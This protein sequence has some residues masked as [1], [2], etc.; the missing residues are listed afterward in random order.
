MGRSGRGNN[1]RLHAFML[2]SCLPSAGSP[3]AIR[4]DNEVPTGQLETGRPNGWHAS[5]PSPADSTAALP[6]GSTV[7]SPSIGVQGTDGA[8][9]SVRVVTICSGLHLCGAP[10][11]TRSCSTLSQA[12]EGVTQ[13]GPCADYRGP[14]TIEHNSGLSRDLVANCPP[15][16]MNSSG[17]KPFFKILKRAMGIEPTTYSLGS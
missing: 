17:R 16:P 14:N 2:N 9:M 13:L 4:S 8:Q 6:S 3:F 15:S 10:P 12:I 7:P 1:P 11:T 5:S